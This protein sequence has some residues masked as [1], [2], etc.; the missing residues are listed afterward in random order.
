[1]G[2]V[3]QGVPQGSVL[4]LL[5][6]IIYINDLPI[7]VKHVSKAILFADVIVTDKD[8]DSFKQKKNLALTSLN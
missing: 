2:I 8:D 6:V 7:S 3:Q 5:L 4:G 1:L